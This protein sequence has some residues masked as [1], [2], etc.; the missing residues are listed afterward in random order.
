MPRCGDRWRI[1]LRRHGGT[2][3]NRRW[4]CAQG[5]TYRH[6]PGSSHLQTLDRS[7]RLVQ[8]DAEGRSANARDACFEGPQ[9]LFGPDLHR[10]PNATLLCAYSTHEVAPPSNEAGGGEPAE[11]LTPTVDNEVHPEV[12]VYLQIFFGGCVE[13]YRHGELVRQG[14]TAAKR[15]LGAGGDMV[16]LHIEERRRPFEPCDQVI[17]RDSVSRPCQVEMAPT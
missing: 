13:D 15:H 17:L 12:D 14:N 5:A 3:E 4:F 16:R 1:V 9:Q 10:P 2:Y 6:G 11:S 8:H 7:A